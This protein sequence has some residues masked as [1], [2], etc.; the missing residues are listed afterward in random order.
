MSRFFNYDV[1]RETVGACLALIDKYTTKEGIITAGVMRRR[2]IP[3]ADRPRVIAPLL[4]QGYRRV[5]P[6]A[7]ARLR[8]LA[9]PGRSVREIADDWGY[10]CTTTQKVL[11]ELGVALPNRMRERAA[12]RRARARALYA[13]GQTVKAIASDIGISLMAVYDYINKSAEAA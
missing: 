2:E 3:C 11:T 8:T 12:F 7:I 4:K 10:S 9:T 1:D 13:Q 5:T 6:A